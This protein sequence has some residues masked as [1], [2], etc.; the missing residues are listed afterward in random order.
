M[1]KQLAVEN[2]MVLL[3]SKLSLEER[4]VL[5]NLLPKMITSI[6]HNALLIAVVKTYSHSRI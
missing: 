5:L 3:P 4:L 2:T 1:L 6:M